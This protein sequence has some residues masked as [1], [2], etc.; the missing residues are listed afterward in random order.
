MRVRP[1][2]AGPILFARSASDAM[3]CLVDLKRSGDRMHQAVVSGYARDELGLHGEDLLVTGDD[4]TDWLDLVG[5]VEPYFWSTKTASLVSAASATYPLEA[6]EA[7]MVSPDLCKPPSYLPRLTRALCVFES[8]CLWIDFDGTPEPLSAIMWGVGISVKTGELR[9]SIR[10]ITWSTGGIA[11]VLFWSDGGSIGSDDEAV[12]STFRSE[13]LAFSKW[14]CT[15][16]MFLEQEIVVAHKESPQR[17]LRRRCER[18]GIVLPSC[19]VVTLRRE[20]GEEIHGHDGG[21]VVEWSHRWVVRGHWRR[22]FYPSR[23]G[24]APVWIHP[25][26]KGPADKPFVDAAPTVYRVAR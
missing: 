23:G 7:I 16:A 2:N 25:H 8:P 20:V 1:A 22:Q 3:Q 15:A 6:E 11:A 5:S 19:H 10:G 4:W 26:V 9:L 13:R 17:A 21:G 14:I 24:H 12:D 18:D